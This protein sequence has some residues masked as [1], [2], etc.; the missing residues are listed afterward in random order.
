MQALT[1]RS[2]ET[3]SH[4]QTKAMFWHLFGSSRGA[5]NRTRIINQIRNNPSN[6]HQLSKDLELEYKGIGHHL[7]ILEK[8]NLIQKFGT[9]YA[10]TY[11]VSSL[12][13]ESESMFDEIVTKLQK[14][15]DKKWSR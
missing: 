3:K 14:T 9:K 8:N 12:F 6:Q 10:S 15:G 4:P 5:L 2:I 13:E 1:L 7:E 11:F